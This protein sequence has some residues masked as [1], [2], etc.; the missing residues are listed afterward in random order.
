M[1]NQGSRL[2]LLLLG[3]GILFV[4]VG[5]AL[6]EEGGDGGVLA[7]F[8]GGVAIPAAF[9]CF[10]QQRRREAFLRW[11]IEN[12][13]SIRKGTADYHG[14]RITLE[15]NLTTMQTVLSVFLVT[16]R[17]PSHFIIAGHD[18]VHLNALMFT[19]FTLVLGWWGLPV[20]PFWTIETAYK[21]L[22]GGET[23]TVGAVL[24]AM[25]RPAVL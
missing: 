6:I 10:V 1:D 21:N 24:D 13:D 4:I 11:L 20:G 25:A 19:F 8:V 18:S 3:L 5:I 22:R 17:L 7:L 14:T 15:T 12:T 23:Q 16:F 2:W 9:V